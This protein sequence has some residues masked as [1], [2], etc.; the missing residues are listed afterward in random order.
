MSWEILRYDWSS[1]RAAGGASH[2]PRAL[3]ALESASTD[4]EAQHAY[5]SI[6]NCVVVQG[7]VHQAAIATASCL[8]GVLL[9]CTDVARRHVLELLVQIGGGEPA[10]SELALGEVDVVIRCL[11]EIAR[12]F[13]VYVSVLE[14]TKDDDE[15]GLCVD[16]LGLS[17]RVDDGLRERVRWYYRMLLLRPV[18]KGTPELISSWIEEIGGSADVLNV[19]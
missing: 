13:P 6:D 16:L 17:C 10:P 11:R 2:I 4:E 3:Q 7:H 1:L 14:R 9:R 15:Q 19:G 18:R 8:L 5:W 12:G